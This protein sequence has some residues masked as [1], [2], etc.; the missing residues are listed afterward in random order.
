MDQ[1]RQLQGHDQHRPRAETD[2]RRWPGSNA[3]APTA[4][5]DAK[6]FGLENVDDLPPETVIPTTGS[7]KLVNPA[8]DLKKIH[9]LTAFSRGLLTNTAT[10][11]WRRDLS[12]MS[13][14]IQLPPLH[15]TCRSSLWPPARCQTYSKAQLNSTANPLIYPWAKYRN[16]ASRAGWAAGAAHLL[17]ERP[18]GLHPAIHETPFQRQCVQNHHEPCFRF[19]HPSTATSFAFQDQVRRCPQ[20]ARIQWIYSIGSRLAQDTSSGRRQIQYRHP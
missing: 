15:R 17:V 18:G 8:A 13:R 19:W 7:L 1:R 9:D 14:E 20:I 4:R 3:C 6:S 12:L 10:G 11:G 2:Q 5:P 16:N